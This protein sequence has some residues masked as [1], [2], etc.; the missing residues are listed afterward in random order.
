MHGQRHQAQCF[1]SKR[2]GDGE[3]KK[4]RRVKNNLHEEKQ[5]ASSQLRKAANAVL[6]LLYMSG[7]A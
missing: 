6:Q 4:S 1:L 3:K 5:D 7:G 2:L